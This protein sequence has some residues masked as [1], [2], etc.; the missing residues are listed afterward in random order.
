[1]DIMKLIRDYNFE[2][3]Q[4]RF[5]E[6]LRNVEDVLYCVEEINNSQYLRQYYKSKHENLNIYNNAMPGASPKTLEL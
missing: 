1:M 6:Y 4:M 2:E 5:V 3:E